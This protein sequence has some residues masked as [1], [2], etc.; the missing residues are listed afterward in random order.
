MIGEWE[1][2]VPD[3]TWRLLAVIDGEPT[4]QRVDVFKRGDDTPDVPFRYD[5]WGWT[6]PS[7]LDLRLIGRFD[8]PQEAKEEGEYWL[9]VT[10]R[11]L[12]SDE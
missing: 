5:V 2:I 12:W 7:M 3:E 1:E 11:E 6:S 4:G 10:T 9:C 8:T